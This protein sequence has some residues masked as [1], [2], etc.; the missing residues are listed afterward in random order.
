VSTATRIFGR[1]TV[2]VCCLLVGLY[3]ALFSSA[4][5][6][7]SPLSAAASPFTGGLVVV[8]S[9]VEREQ[10][11]ASEEA[12]LASPGRIA[13]RELSRTLFEGLSA[14]QAEGVAADVFPSLIDEPTGGAPRLPAGA[15]S[16]GYPSANAEAVEL[17]EEKHA[18]VESAAPIA[19]ET[20]SGGEAPINLGLSEANGAFVPLASPVG[21]RIPQQLGAG[22]VLSGTGVSLAPVE[23]SGSPVGGSEGVVDGAS[24]FYANTQTDTDTVVKPT[25]VGVET[26]SL[27]RSPLSPEQLTYR[28]GM[29]EGG[30][31][32]MDPKTGVGIVT[33]NGRE[34]ATI[35]PP[36]A[37]DAAG[38]SVPVSMSV[39]G[40]LLTVDVE[41]ATAKYQYPID[42]DPYFIY[43][44]SIGLTGTGPSN[45][46]FLTNNP[47][48][49]IDNVKASEIEITTA[50]K[51]SFVAGEYAILSYSTQGESWIS[52]F[53]ASIGCGTPGAP[54]E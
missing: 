12:R 33:V 40:A 52:N 54:I 13:E 49:W 5:A 31:L 44:S 36:V 28:V 37:A 38:V 3:A 35:L 14:Q 42:V 1:V 50:Y 27:L 41:G 7:T 17:P 51:A 19:M 15:K 2:A 24:V 45:W 6:E 4:S 32:A 16:V 8:G 39:K 21:V 9:L 11:R 18:V 43:D 30:R 29:P 48:G 23:A 10:V 25:S 53:Q 34:V 20:S 46:V 26:S 47:A 22:I